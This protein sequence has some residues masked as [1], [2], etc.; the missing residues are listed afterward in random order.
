MSWRGI[1]LH[2]LEVNSNTCNVLVKLF[3]FLSDNLLF[4]LLSDHLPPMLA[5]EME[6]IVSL[7][8]MK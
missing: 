2:G 1:K 6:F 8:G 5:K 4:L 7:R 3:I